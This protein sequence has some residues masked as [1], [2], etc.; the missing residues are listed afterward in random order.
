MALIHNNLL[1]NKHSQRYTPF[2]LNLVSGR[3]KLLSNAEFKTV[4][5]M[6][7]KQN[8]AQYSED[9][10]SLYKRL[11]MEKQ[12]IDDNYRAEIEEKMLETKL[13]QMNNRPTDDF[14]FTVHLTWGC[15]MSCVYCYANSYVGEDKTVTTEQIDSIY[16]FF[17][18][19][20]GDVDVKKNTSA[21]CVTGG[22]PLLNHKSVRMLKYLAS[23]WPEAKLT[24]IT[25]GINLLKYYDELPIQN[26]GEVHVSLDGLK[27]P[28]LKRR[29][30]GGSVPKE[31]V[32]DNIVQGI[33]RLLGDEIAVVI[34]T[35]ID[36]HNYT[37]FPAFFTYLEKEKIITSPF[38]THQ[39]A[40]VQDYSNPLSIDES[41]NNVDEIRKIREHVYPH[42]EQS[43]PLLGLNPLYRV[44]GRDN[45]EPYIPKH[46]RCKSNPLS[47]YVFAPDGN[48]YFCI[49][50]SDESGIIGT[51]HPKISLNESVISGLANRSVFANEECKK[52]PYKFVCLGD[53]PKSAEGQWSDMSRMSCGPF[54]Y[55]EIMDNIEFD[56]RAL[57]NR[58]IPVS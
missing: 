25:N 26:F 16:K 54:K 9:D 6:I 46:I 41:F 22:E 4:C 51:Y 29:F 39:V 43:P 44:M 27:E 10:I 40:H 28:H 3:R 36:K 11:T 2:L 24:M 34:K 21:I 33:K 37:E 20:A 42:L 14:I 12:F 48:I 23:K 56:Y 47:N 31:G 52:C 7:E 5:S 35:C 49:C 30:G 13:F 17:G 53:C 57:A 18:N 8:M 1:I 32:Y 45:N 55:P 38:C 15:N 58:A 19:Y 50:L